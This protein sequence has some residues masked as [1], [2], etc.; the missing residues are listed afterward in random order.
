MHMCVVLL[1]LV[2]CMTLLASFFLPSASLVSMYMHRTTNS[3][4][5]YTYTVTTSGCSPFMIHYDSHSSSYSLP[6]QP[7]RECVVSTSLTRWTCETKW[8]ST[9]PWSSRRSPSPRPAS[10]QHSTPAPQSW[11]LLT[12]LEVATNAA[13]H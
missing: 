8:P 10:R 12:P 4:H 11:R 6:P 9:K 7:H 5:A 3:Q 2:V 13:S 1:C